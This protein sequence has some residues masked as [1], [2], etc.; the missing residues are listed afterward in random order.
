MANHKLSVSVGFYLMLALML[1][2]M[3]LR[4]LF[5]AIIAA[6][7]HECCH[8]AAIR[9]LCRR[10][11]TVGLYSYGARMALP[12]MSRSKELLCAMAGPAGGFLLTALAP[13]FPRLALCAFVQSAYNLLP[14]YP[15][16][17]GRMFSSILYMVF[18]PPLAE[19]I[20]R[21]TEVSIKCILCLASLYACFFLRWGILPL[22]IAALICIRIK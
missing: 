14:V 3:P 12:E 17:G 6:I 2:L 7:F 20:L 13:L 18:R 10:P 22:L 4:W 1:L 21:L 5:S 15:L 11:A 9:L 16:D 19:A 8:Y